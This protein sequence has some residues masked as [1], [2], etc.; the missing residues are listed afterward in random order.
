VKFLI[1]NILAITGTV[2]AATLSASNNA[3]FNPAELNSIAYSE[4]YLFNHQSLAEAA[5][6]YCGDH[7]AENELARDNCD[8]ASRV[9][10]PLYL[11]YFMLSEISTRFK[12]WKVFF[13]SALFVLS[14]KK[15]LTG[16]FLD[17]ARKSADSIKAYMKN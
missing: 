9:N 13:F 6:K 12:F 3:G 17:K 14:I 5:G 15:L 10:N 2:N 8:N 7:I 16:A 11:I 1:I 4:A